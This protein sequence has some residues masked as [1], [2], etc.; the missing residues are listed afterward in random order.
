MN[1]DIFN[2]YGSVPTRDK[3]TYES[4]PDAMI[5]PAHMEKTGKSDLTQY[6]SMGKSPNLGP[7][8]NMGDGKGGGDNRGE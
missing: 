1:G 5:A 8:G 3:E 2:K 4:S 7:L 6:N